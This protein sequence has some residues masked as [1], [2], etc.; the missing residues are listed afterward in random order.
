[1][2]AAWFGSSTPLPASHPVVGP[3]AAVAAG[4]PLADKAAKP[5]VVAGITEPSLADAAKVDPSVIWRR[6][7]E[8]YQRDVKDYRCVLTKQEQLADGLTPLQEIE[9]RYR[10]QPETVYMIWRKNADEVKRALYMD[11]PEYIDGKGQRLARVEP[12]GAIVSLFVRD[13]K[14]PI[15]GERAQKASRRSIRDCNFGATFTLLE[16]INQTAADRGVLDI[17]YDGAGSIDG[18]PS[19]VVVRYLPYEGERG[20]FPDA[21]LIIHFD[22]ETLLPVAMYSYSD[23]AGKQLLGSYVFTKIELNPGFDESAFKF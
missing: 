10:R 21:K 1:M 12:A 2:P 6:G 5:T 9:V 11:S 23:R 15:Q 4:P 7:L 17:R 19:Y 16:K 3:A 18:R 14:T 22:Q 13:I 8:R 20:P